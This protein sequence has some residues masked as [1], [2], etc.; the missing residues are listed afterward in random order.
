MVHIDFVKGAEPEQGVTYSCYSVLPY[1]HSIG[2]ASWWAATQIEI[3]G[4][5][6][7]REWAGRSVVSTRSP[8]AS[9]ARWGSMGRGA[10]RIEGVSVDVQRERMHFDGCFICMWGNAHMCTSIFLCTYRR[11]DICKSFKWVL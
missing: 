7:R 10:K 8:G 2:R 5:A 6:G 11:T 3:P 4:F 1:Q 9:G